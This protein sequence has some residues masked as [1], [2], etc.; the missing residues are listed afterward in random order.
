MIFSTNNTDTHE[1]APQLVADAS[2]AATH[3]A[4]IARA[5]V[6]RS[7][8]ELVTSPSSEAWSI[9]RMGAAIDQLAQ[10]AA[11]LPFSFDTS[12]L[13]ECATRTDTDA[14]DRAARE[15]GGQFEVGEHG[16]PL[17]IR[18]E[19]APGANPA[20]KEELARFYELFGYEVDD[21]D[22]WQLDHLSVQ[23]EFL[24]LLS[25]GAAATNDAE[26]ALS[27]QCAARD[28]LRRHLA[29]WLPTMAEKLA[30]ADVQPYL[31]AVMLATAAFVLA[32]HDWLNTSISE[33]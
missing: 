29:P 22:A 24:H 2:T 23:L 5:L 25:F 20:S 3:A 14:L 15:Y 26:A 17:P 8:C 12:A 13:E 19:L 1:S 33:E 7:L 30:A 16:P 27:F 11:A 10:A 21:A 18:A 9:E 32:D 4:H 31:R 6:Y 28:V